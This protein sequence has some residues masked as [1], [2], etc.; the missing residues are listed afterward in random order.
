MILAVARVPRA[1]YERG[2]KES[3]LDVDGVSVVLVGE[4]PRVAHGDC[5]SGIR[6][7]G[8]VVVERRPAIAA[9]VSPV[10]DCGCADAL[11]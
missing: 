1:P 8:V 2:G 5:L 9:D 7:A 11:D 4:A 3:G 6:L 10:V